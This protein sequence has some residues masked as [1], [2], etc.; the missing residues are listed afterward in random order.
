MDFEQGFQISDLVRMARRRAWLVAAVAGACLLASVFVA[1]ILPNEYASSATLLVEPQTIS[2]R[3]VESGLSDRDVNSRLHLIQMQILSRGRLSRVIE[4]LGLYKAESQEMTREKVISLMRDEITLEPVLPELEQ[5]LKGRREVEINTFRLSFRHRSARL[6][7]DVTNRLANDFIDEHIKERVEIAGDTFEFI[8]AELNRLTQRMREVENQIASG[9]SENAGQLP[10]DMGSNQRQLERSL[11]GIRSAEREL[12]M[13]QSDESFFNQQAVSAAVLSGGNEVTNPARRLEAL[14]LDLN[15]LRS[16]GLT[17]AHPDIIST[18]EQIDSLRAQLEAE[19]ASAGEEEEEEARTDQP[20]S[21]AQQNAK[22]E[23]DRARLRV[24]SARAEIERLRK[25]AGDF[26]A[27]L[28]ATPRVAEQLA[29]FE[30][31]QLHLIKSYQE[32]SRKRLDANVSADMER[33]QKG[34]QFRVLEAAYPSP[35]AV[36]PN[37]PVIVLLGLVMGVGLGGVLAFLLEAADTSY[38]SSRT[39][40]EQLRI[41]VLASIPAVLLDSDRMARRRMHVRRALAA[42]AL[43]SIV[44]VASVVGNW[45]VNGLPGPLRTLIEGQTEA[46]PAPPAA[47]EQG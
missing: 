20:L 38:K 16:R 14:E 10:E 6:A 24:A 29:A 47:G 17:D 28:A 32:Y 26:E 19:A 22:A 8:Q 7:A 1:S 36:S 35:E 43:T 2:S 13:A 37:R 31:E 46:E 33:R 39:L 27:R 44:L 21:L 15:A 41:P 40:Q 34:E 9:K 25:E 42:A 23:A 3:L 5:Q 18:T 11:A 4:E 30:R 45:T 12:A